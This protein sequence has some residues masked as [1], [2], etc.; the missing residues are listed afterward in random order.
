MNFINIHPLLFIKWETI[1]LHM[2][3]KLLD[4]AKVVLPEF[5]AAVEG[6]PHPWAYLRIKSVSR[7]L[8]VTNG[9]AGPMT[10]HGIADHYRVGVM[11]YLLDMG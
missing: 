1:Y 8:R 9:I 5:G 11:H 6:L 3:H 10:D 2:P 4:I 7:I